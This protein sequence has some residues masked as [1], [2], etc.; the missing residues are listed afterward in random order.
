LRVRQEPGQSWETVLSGF[1]TRLSNF[2]RLLHLLDIIEVSFH[3]SLMISVSNK[4]H[5][6]KLVSTVSTTT[7]SNNNINNNTAHPANDR[8][9]EISLARQLRRTKRR[10]FL[11]AVL[12]KDDDA[13]DQHHNHKLHQQLG[14]SSF[15]TGTKNSKSLTSYICHCPPIIATIFSRAA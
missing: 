14:G 13:H 9:H 12:Q 10:L 15:V 11:D 4:H 5:T 1:A 3:R 8:R 2:V 7:Y 6:L